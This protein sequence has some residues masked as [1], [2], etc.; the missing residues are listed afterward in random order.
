MTLELLRT[1]GT[2][3]QRR[4]LYARVVLGETFERIPVP[5][6]LP[7]PRLIRQGL[8]FALD[9]ISTV[10][11]SPEADWRV[12]VGL[13]TC[14]D[15]VAA[16]LPAKGQVAAD[17]GT[18]PPAALVSPDHVLEL[19]P[20][21]TRLARLMQVFLQAAICRGESETAPSREKSGDLR[22]E[23]EL[24]DAMILKV[25]SVID[26][27]QVD[28]PPLDIARVDC[29]CHALEIACRRCSG[30]ITLRR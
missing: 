18:T 14:M 7:V 8:S 2:T 3:E 25:A 13:G 30:E 23:L 28:Q 11:G 15:E 4:A 17:D 29:L 6:G 19:G 5:P 21:S 9:Q 20:D 10:Y 24:L 1:G 12:L 26:A 27:L 22:V 16:I